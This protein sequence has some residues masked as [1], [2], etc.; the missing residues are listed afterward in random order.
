[1]ASWSAVFGVHVFFLPFGIVVGGLFLFCVLGVM[2]DLLMF[3]ALSAL[4]DLKEVTFL[5]EGVNMIYE[6]AETPTRTKP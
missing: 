3:A 6:V 2:L 4:R 1:M 5:K